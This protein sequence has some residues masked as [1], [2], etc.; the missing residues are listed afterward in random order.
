MVDR[1][2]SLGSGRVM[3]GGEEGGR[4]KSRRVGGTTTGPAAFDVVNQHRW[5]CAWVSRG[6]DEKGQ[7]GWRQTLRALV[8]RMRRLVEVGGLMEEE[9]GSASGLGVDASA[10]SSSFSQAKKLL[11]AM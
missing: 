11:D 2:S 1:R 10:S 6:L 4:A 8:G 9:G 5:W 7:P 3:E